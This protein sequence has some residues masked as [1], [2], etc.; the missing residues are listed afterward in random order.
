M[1]QLVKCPCVS[2]LYSTRELLARTTCATDTVAGA[3]SARL[4]PSL[5]PRGPG[6]DYLCYRCCSLCSLCTPRAF[7]QLEFV[8]QA[9]LVPSMLN[10]GQSLNAS[11]LYSTFV[12]LAGSTFVAD[13]AACTVSKRLEPIL[14]PRSPGRFDLCRQCCSMSS[15]S[16]TRAFTRSKFSW[17]A[18]PVPSMLQLVQSP[19][20]SSPRSTRF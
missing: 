11:G 10:L 5:N 8:W 9:L 18:L 4:E 2:S 12:V 19:N 7:T 17:Q 6:R 14:D 13:A 3:I 20:L 16:T 15:L 1:M